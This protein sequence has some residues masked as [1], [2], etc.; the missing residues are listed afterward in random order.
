MKELLRASQPEKAKEL[1]AKL[2]AWRKE[3]DGAMPAQNP[4]FNPA[5]K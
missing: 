4:A 1:H 2:V 3:V 5:A